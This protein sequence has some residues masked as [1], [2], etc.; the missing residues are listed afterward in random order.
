MDFFQAGFYEFI[1]AL[2]VVALAWRGVWEWRNRA[3]RATAGGRS[4]SDPRPMKF[5]RKSTRSS[6]Q[7]SSAHGSQDAGSSQSYSQRPFKPFFTSR[8]PHRHRE[9]TKEPI[10]ESTTV[11]MRKQVPP[12]EGPPRSWFGGLPMMPDG[13]EWPRGINPEVDKIND[14]PLHFVCQIALADLPSHLWAGLGPREG[15]LLFF[16]NNNHHLLDEYG[17]TRFIHT[18]ELGEERQP[19]ADI[20]PIHDG[21]YCGSTRWIS[22]N[23]TY[24][25]VPVDLVSMPNQLYEYDGCKHAV[26]ENL[27]QLLNE[28]C[29]IGHNGSFRGA[30]RPFTWRGLAQ[31]LDTL[32]KAMDDTKVYERGERNRQSMRDRFVEP[33]NFARILKDKQAE[34]DEALSKPVQRFETDSDEFFATRQQRGQARIE[35]LKNDLE[36]TRA[37][38][39]AYPTADAL[40]EQL[41]SRT[42]RDWQA[43]LRPGLEQL[44]AFG[45]ERGLDTPLSDEEWSAVR[46]EL[47][48]GDTKLW[49]LAWSRGR[50]GRSITVENHELTV[51]SLIERYIGEAIGNTIKL[52]YPDPET[53]KL[54]PADV[55]PKY[56]AHLRSLFD[57]IPQK[58]GGY[59]DGVQSECDYRPDDRMLLLQ[60]NCDYALDMIWGDCG[61]VYAWIEPEDLKRGDFNKASVH[62][63][64]H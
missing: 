22:H 59:H 58:M 51:F 40:L 34:L 57:G 11:V 52:Y 23:K 43:S 12:R 19:P 46:S 61:G 4:Q 21:V 18:T 10:K 25:Y 64:C 27:A 16:V 24:P 54:I 50:A 37:L 3:R 48:T 5:A 44:R 6:D 62:L 36:E 7:S 1:M 32:F 31:T 39:E 8:T 9:E 14:V 49:M 30:E 55:L 33:E 35:R 26:P 2:F 20:G 41:Q 13:V 15:W 29:E 56:E 42:H 53:R 38:L 47:A 17:V 45:E 63:E 60:L 28:G